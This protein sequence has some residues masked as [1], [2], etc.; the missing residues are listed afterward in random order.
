MF[1]KNVFKI[2]IKYMSLHVMVRL[3]STYIRL[4]TK[5]T[6]KDIAHKY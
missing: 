1:Y 4:T 5:I 3:Q 2:S 6:K